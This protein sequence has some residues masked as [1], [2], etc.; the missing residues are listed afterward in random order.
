MGN[1]PVVK[2][3]FWCVHGNAKPVDRLFACCS[4]C[5]QASRFFRVPLQSPT[6]RSPRRQQLW[7]SLQPCRVRSERRL[8]VP[9]TPFRCLAD[10]GHQL[11]TAQLGFGAEI[12]PSKSYAHRG[13][14]SS[15][16]LQAFSCCGRCHPIRWSDEVGS[17]QAAR[18][19][20]RGSGCFLLRTMKRT[21]VALRGEE[22]K[23]EDCEASGPKSGCLRRPLLGTA[24]RLPATAWWSTSLAIVCFDVSL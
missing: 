9:P 1:R 11:H 14:A 19:L 17:V 5:T 21:R 22:S 12:I 10:H 8:L 16:H 24:A 23:P 3:F 2:G 15:T 6:W 20:V 4:C 13:C 7:S 18:R